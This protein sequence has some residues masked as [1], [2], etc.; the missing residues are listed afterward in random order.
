MSEERAAPTMTPDLLHSWS[1][2][3]SRRRATVSGAIRDLGRSFASWVILLS[4]AIDLLA[5]VIEPTMLLSRRAPVGAAIAA[6]LAAIGLSML[7][8]MVAAVPIAAI[9][10]FVRIIGRL[11]RPFNHFWPIPLLAL[12]W[13]VILNVAPHPVVNLGIR[14]EVRLVLFAFLAGLMLLATGVARLRDV[15]GRSIC[16]ALLGAAT[17]GVSFALPP[18]IHREPRDVVWLSLIVSAAALIYPLRRTLR[19]MSHE[20]VARIFFVVGVSS[21]ACGLLSDIVSP[22]WRVYARDHGRYAERLGRFCRTI[23]DFDDDGFSAILGGLDCDDWDPARNPVAPESAVGADRNCNGITRPDAPT[24]AERGLAPPVGDP[25]AAPGEIERVLLVTVDCL[26]SDV[27]RPDVTP[28]LSR[29]AARG[30]TFSKLYAGG[31]RTTM[32]L[33]LLLRG[34]YRAPSVAATL[35]TANVTSTAVFSYRHT[36]LEDN[37]F[38]GFGA[39][40]RP[41]EVDHRFRATEVTDRALEDLA[42]AS[43]ASGQFLWVHYFDAHGPRNAR[44][45]PADLPHFAPL[46]GEDVASSL[47]LS[48]L[49]YDDRE[50]GRLLEGVERIGGLAKTMILVTGDHGEGFGLHGEYEHGQ[51]AFDEIIHVPGIFV[52]PGVPAGAFDHVASHRDIAATILGAFG[53]V[54]KH[55]EIEA[56][57]RSWLRLRGSLAAPLH[58]FVI[59]YSTSTH[60]LHWPDAPMVVRTD[61]QGKFAVGYREGI[62]RLYHPQSAVGEWRDVAPQHPGEAARDRL[63]LEIYRDIDSSPP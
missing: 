1:P 62:V 40:Q 29:L 46:A 3:R 54:A 2:G 58:D 37:A 21:L 18:S 31:A 50:I 22:N 28:N 34:S 14:G 17:L 8:S 4:L 24:D 63:E 47:Y 61:D 51:S 35:A 32:S 56:F 43:Q 20:R 49:A 48:E 7:F 23:L 16:G 11:P 36:T 19:T 42:S 15:R 52:A 38:E 39:V 55:P 30:V 41:A 45:L 59:T 60:V 57:G 27:L 13:L 9:Y 10:S 44:V 53:L 12:A 5:V 26:R 33:P 25:D 6:T